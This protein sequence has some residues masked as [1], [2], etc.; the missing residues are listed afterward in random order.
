[1]KPGF[2]L[3]EL[4]I[5]LLVIAIL[6]SFAV[7]R[8]TLFTPSPCDEFATHFNRL[9]RL[10]YVRALQTGKLHRIFFRVENLTMQ[11]E[12]EKSISSTG[13]R[14]FDSVG[15]MGVATQYAWSPFVEIRNFFIKKIDEN[16]RGSLKEAWLY[17]FPAGLTQ[18]AII[19]I[20]DNQRHIVRGLVINPFSSQCV[21][22]ETM[23]KP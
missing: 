15:A 19:N 8:I 21:I 12:V 5:V 11:V 3:I 23:Q 10:A 22:H 2:S 1:M 20:E 17:I 9:L 7:P 18:E 13:K 4:V 16:A 14:V 6:A